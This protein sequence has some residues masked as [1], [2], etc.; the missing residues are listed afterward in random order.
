[1][2]YEFAL[3]RMLRTFE[4]STMIYV[5]QILKSLILQ[6]IDSRLEFNKINL[7][8]VTL[9]CFK[10]EFQNTHSIASK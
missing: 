10:L 5:A 1:M 6:S 4:G 8:S 9:R 3:D 7:E 2:N